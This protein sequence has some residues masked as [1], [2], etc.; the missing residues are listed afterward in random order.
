VQNAHRLA[1]SGIWLRH[2]GHSRVVWATSGSVRRRFISTFTGFTT[3]KNTTA[4]IT[5]NA[6]SALKNEP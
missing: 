6:I 1:A 3:R 5:M 4:A 2:S